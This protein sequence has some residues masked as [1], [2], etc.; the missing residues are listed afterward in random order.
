MSLPISEKQLERAIVE[1]ARFYHWMVFHARPAQTQK[2]WRT[3]VA[4]DGKG[5]PDLTLVG[6]R[7]VFAEIKAKG[8]KLSPD[9]IR[10]REQIQKAGGEWYLW[11]PT[12]WEAGEVQS[13]ASALRPV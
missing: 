3:P 2:G 9:Q 5:F 13:I 6:A 11:T 4:Y 10:W 7:V 8:G 1:M 12:E